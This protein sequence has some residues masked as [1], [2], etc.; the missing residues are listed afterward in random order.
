[1]RD[2]GYYI[3]LND[4]WDMAIR[5][6]LYSKGSH[7]ANMIGTYRKNYKYD[8]NVNLRYASTRTGIEGTPEYKPSKDFY[9]QWSHS[10]R[11]EANPGTSFSASVNVGTSSYFSR[12]AAGGTYNLDQLTR[13][14]LSS[15]I[16]YGRSIADGLF[17][18]SSSLSH[19]QDLSTK[20]IFLQLPSFNLSMTTL[21]P[22]DSKERVGEQ[23]WYQKVSV[24]YNLNGSN[25]IDTKEY[26]LFKKGSLQ[27]F[28]SGFQHKIPVNL[29]LN[30][31]KFFQFSSGV[32][33]NE[34]WYL[35]TIR[36]NFISATET[37][38]KDTLKGF[39]RAYDY[40][41][42]TGFSTKIYGIKNFKKGKLLALRH[43]MTPSVSFS[44]RPDFGGDHYG[45]YRNV[46]TNNSGGLER[47][48]I[49]E[50]GEFGSPGIGKQA[51]MG[52][53]IDNNIEAKFR[54]K[55]DTT[56]LPQKVSILQSLSFSSNYNFAADSFKLSN[57]SFSG[58]TALFKQTVGINFYGTFDPYKLNGLGQR[59]DQFTIRDWK[60]A[61]LTNV[62]LS[63]DFSLNSTAAKK[64]NTMIDNTVLNTFN[65]R[66]TGILCWK[67]LLNFC[68]LPFLK[69]R[70]SLVSIELLPL[71]LYPT[72]TF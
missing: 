33:Y 6:T 53:S 68:K 63:F 12:T 30:V 64:R 46:Q 55:S 10:Q 62:G 65:E 15:S 25:S 57:I 11:A 18:F 3:G 37:V 41:L 32:G 22:F 47:Y 4:Y 36:K 2:L 20:N 51:A 49:F 43:V 59:I 56:T 16:N 35:Q 9:I 40:N 28:K 21:N 66:F 69:R 48:S 14:S 70:Y 45:F 61:R 42:S 38:V 67:P 71:R 29:S 39:S 26:L 34:T 1:M 5:T 13:N 31:F 7:E 23:K 60:L 19:R 27:K 58:R 17:T 8:G 50:D 44:Y 52:F 54:S 72:E 24:G